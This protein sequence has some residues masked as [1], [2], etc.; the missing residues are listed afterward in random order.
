M[1]IVRVSTVYIIKSKKVD[2]TSMR[3]MVKDANSDIT[4]KR[5]EAT[6]PKPNFNCD[7][8]LA[9]LDVMD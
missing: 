7:P 2:V 6:Y 9:M 3:T 4:S 5:R 1:I 8:M